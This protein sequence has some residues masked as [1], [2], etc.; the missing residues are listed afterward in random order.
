MLDAS[1]AQIAPRPKSPPKGLLAG[2]ALRPKKSRDARIAVIGL[3]YVGLPLA[4]RLSERFEGV[5]GF[6]ISLTRVA[7]IGGGRDVTG[8]VTG[9][10]LKASELLATGNVARLAEADV[11][12]LTVPTPVT[13][14]NQPDLEPLRSACRM[15]APHLKPGDIV[16]FEST[17]YPGVTED[18]CGPIL[19]EGSGLDIGRDVHLGYSPERI[20]PGDRVNTVETI[21]KNVAASDEATLKRLAN[22][23]GK[24]IDAGVH[25]CPSIRV[26]EAAKVL[27]NTQRD[28]NIALM[29]ELA[30]ICQRMG[31]ATRD[32]IEAAATKW[33]FV[34]F[35]P[36]LVGGHCIGVDPYYLAAAAERVGH[37]PEVILSGR[38][39]N[40]S[41]PGKVAAE[42]VRRLILRDGKMRDMRIGVLG[43]AFKENVPDIRNSKVIE[44][45]Q[46]LRGFGLDPIVHDPL[47]DAKDA[48]AAG[49][50]L[51]PMADL[52]D[53]DMAVLGAPHRA[54][55]DDPAFLSILRPDGILA[56]IRGALAKA[57]RPAGLD[58]WAL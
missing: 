49:L 14:A 42:L 7:Q 25:L 3:G 15:V 44:L 48:K 2:K 46:E 56:D 45:V 5:I 28:V 34:P 36:G 26:A 53:L 32:V 11:Y 12:I 16:V 6:D 19:A 54:Y 4:V 24:V 8:E 41:M 58:Y 35:T 40:D 23:Y 13:E 27:E 33:N 1:D 21:R 31:I 9:D 43:I 18:F 37:H 22:I 20:N 29:N 57:P 50:E 38:R 55:L 30:L 51:R 52:T 47:C 10:R 17:V 39:L